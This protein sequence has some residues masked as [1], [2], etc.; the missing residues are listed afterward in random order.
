MACLGFGAALFINGGMWG[1]WLITFALAVKHDRPIPWSLLAQPVVS[2][3]A[4]L[5]AAWWVR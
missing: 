5:L 2:L 4:I 1:M 3:V